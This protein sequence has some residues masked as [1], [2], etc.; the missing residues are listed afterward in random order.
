L[1]NPQWTRQNAQFTPYINPRAFSFPAP[2]RYGNAPRNL[3]MAYPWVRSLD[4]SFFKRI[5]PFENA[6][7][8]FELRAEIFNILNHKNYLPNPNP[9]ALL[10]GA[11][12]NPLLTGTSPNF[13]PVPNVQN[14]Y[15]N[16]KAPGVW[17]AIIR[18]SEG[19]PVDQAIGALAGPGANGVGCPANA[20][21]LGAGNQTLALS[22]ACVA[23]ALNLGGLRLNANSIAPRTVQFA[24]K[25]YF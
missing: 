19:V 23:R 3:D 21:E 2:G 20:Q 18:K 16:L 10:T 1:V 4:M 11:A 9:Q 24:L 12:Q 6:R 8:Y 22:P 25:F 13:T 14:R 5:R 15:E 17:D 7:R